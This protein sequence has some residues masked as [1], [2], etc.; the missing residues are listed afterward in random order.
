MMELFSESLW[1]W[2]WKDKKRSLQD[3]QKAW[4]EYHRIIELHRISPNIMN[5]RLLRCHL[6][7]TNRKVR[8][9]QESQQSIIHKQSNHPPSI[10]KQIPA[11]VIKRISNISC[12]KECFDKAAPDY[13]NALKNSSFNENIKFTPRLPNRRKLSRNILWFNPPFN[14]NVKTNIGK[15]FC[16]S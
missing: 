4:V 11:M 1:S 12:D 15:Y 3:L 8:P 14:S 2:I 10:T 7:F 9:I 16:N 13:N 5:Y 6:W